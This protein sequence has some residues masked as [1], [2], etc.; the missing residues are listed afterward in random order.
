VDYPNKTNGFEY[1]TFEGV[2]AELRATKLVP[3]EHVYVYEV[4]ADW[5]GNPKCLGGGDYMGSLNHWRID[6]FFAGIP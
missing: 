4:S 5:Y 6:D 1:L 2:E 3:G